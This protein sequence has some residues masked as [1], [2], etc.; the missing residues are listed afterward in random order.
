MES[1][2]DLLSAFQRGVAKMKPMKMIKRAQAGFTLIELMIVVAIIGI[3][4]A[5]AIPAYQDYITKAKLSK[6]LAAIDSIKLAVAETAQNN[7]GAVP[8]AGDAVTGA[9]AN[10]ISLGFT[11]T[12][13]ATTEATQ[14]KVLAAGNL[15]D[16]QVTIGGIGAPYNTSTVTFRP[17]LASG[18]VLTWGITCSITGNQNMTK[19]FGCP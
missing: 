19:I 9:V 3:L 4:A 11:N 5:V 12:P 13:T 2:A 6:V 18:N 14:I 8:L 17:S 10:W 7:A 16:I 1:L 15:G